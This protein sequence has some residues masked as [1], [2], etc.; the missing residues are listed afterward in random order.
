MNNNSATNNIITSEDINSSK[1]HITVV[2][3]AYNEA[4]HIQKNLITTANIISTFQKDFRIIAVNDGSRDNTFQE[5]KA[6]AIRDSHICFV[7]YKQNRGKGHAIATG[8]AQANSDYIAFLDS[9]LELSPTMLKDFLAS[10]K[11]QNADIAIGS[12]LH[13]DSKLIYPIGRKILS[14]GYYIILK[15]MF[16]LNIKDTQTGIKLFKSEVIKPICQDL[17]TDGFAFDIEILATASK[18]GCK[19]IE[20]PI[21]LNYSRNKN[22]KSKVSLKTVNKVFKDTLKIKKK[23]KSLK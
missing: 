12:K 17:C 13:K 1:T 9:D 6:A 21:E 10:I 5:I 16:N 15:I 7:H 22:E 2:M 3:P 8:V 23:I 14:M 20:M 4:N 18:Q 11:K 19:I